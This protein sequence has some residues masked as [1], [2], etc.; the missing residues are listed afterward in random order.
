VKN[1]KRLKKEDAVTILKIPVL[2]I[3][4]GDASPLLASLGG[5]V[6]PASWRG[7][8]P[9]TYHIGGGEE[10]KVQ[11]KIKQSWDI[12]PAYNVVAKIKGSTYP[13]EWIIRGNHHDAWVNGASD[14]VSGL[15]SVLEEAKAIGEL[16]KAGYKPKRTLVY[17][18]WDGEEPSLLGSTEWVEDH[19]S[20]LSEKAV[21]YINTDNNSSGFLR[22]GGSHALNG[23]VTAVAK[24]V[25]DPQSGVS[26]FERKRANDA[27]NANTAQKS[28]AILKSDSYTLGALGT[29]SDYSAFL[30][31]LGIPSLNYSFSGEAEGGEYH[32]VYD[33]YDNYIRFKDPDFSYG[34][35]LSQVAGHT[36]LSL[37]EAEKLPFDFEG[38]Y[39]AIKSYADDLK[40]QT[41]NLRAAN[42]QQNKLI[43]SGVYKTAGGTKNT[44]TAPKLEPA[45]PEID[46]NSLNTALQ[47]LKTEIVSLKK[48]QS[49]F[50]GDAK[51]IQLNNKK[52]YR[53]EQS[54]LLPEGL[55]RRPWYKHSIYAPGFYTGYGVKTIPGVR[56]ALEEGQ[57][58][59]LKTELGRVVNALN[60]LNTALKNIY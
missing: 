49:D 60:Q 53:A 13:D 14:P 38:L 58:E 37:A 3:G 41:D 1:A 32:S 11:L 52:L 54:L 10:S 31:H 42:T 47:Q 44:V 18:A 25:K 9:F 33:S 30:Q 19:A 12:V 43:T 15:A 17:C 4:Y 5:P 46:Y 55:P 50:T 39:T 57:Y 28:D 16:V 2:P 35:A 40:T 48:R 23:L 24:E 20:E 34:V 51:A 6:A 8:L 21:A 27:I 56:E 29:G 26:V 45:V 7:A 59:E 36:V 22:A